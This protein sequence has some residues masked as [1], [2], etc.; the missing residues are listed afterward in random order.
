MA[1]KA[2]KSREGRAD[3]V[4]RPRRRSLLRRILRRLVQL[5]V[6][7]L[8][9]PVLLLPLYRYVNPPL[10]SVMVWKRLGGASIV[11]HW[12]DIADIS[13]NLVRAVLVSE[14]ARFCAHGGIDLKEVEAVLEDL[15]EGE[16]LR[17]ASTISMQVVKNLFLWSDRSFIRKALEV[18]LALY[19]ELVMPKKR[20]ME[21]YLNIVEWD[22]GVYG[23]EAAAQHYFNVSASRL[24]R[25]QAAQLAVT[26][27][28][29]T[30]RDAAQPSRQ[31]RKLAAIVARRADQ[32]GAYVTCVLD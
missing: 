32:S 13:P 15:G 1:E 18:P 16:S 5:T 20:I 17:G 21:I 4:E 30:S 25:G 14:D 7:L 31:M 10:T 19:N 26:L 28:A 11:R 22:R 27:P 23:A 12:V 6:L 3:R 29:P 8:L 9:V 2:A 24:S